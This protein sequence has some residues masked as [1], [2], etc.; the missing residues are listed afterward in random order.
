MIFSPRHT[1]EFRIHEATLNHQKSIN[2]LFICNAIV[3]YAEKHVDDIFT[4]KKITMT[5][6]L[7]YYRDKFNNPDAAF[8][9]KY[10]IAYF[11]ERSK[12]FNADR[13]IGDRLSEHTI[14]ND[15]KYKFSFEGVSDL[16]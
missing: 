2:W 4:G 12:M 10:L 16:F 3:R 11:N 5:Q 7:N 15:K 6:I 8:L 9:S 13:A 14:T 1:A